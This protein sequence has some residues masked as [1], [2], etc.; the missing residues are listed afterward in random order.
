M[1]DAMQAERFPPPTNLRSK[2]AYVMNGVPLR[3]LVF[4]LRKVCRLQISDM[5]PECLIQA[6]SSFAETDTC[7]VPKSSNGL[8]KRCDTSV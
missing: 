7:N 3:A 8:N 4:E 5:L 1:Q 6:D 2:L